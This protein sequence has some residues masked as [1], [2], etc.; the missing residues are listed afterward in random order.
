MLSALDMYF[1]VKDYRKQDL[2]DI[3][4]NLQEDLC[5]ERPDILHVTSMKKRMHRKERKNIYVEETYVQHSH[6]VQ[7][8]GQ[9]EK[10]SE[11]LTKISTGQ[12]LSGGQEEIVYD[13]LE[14]FKSGQKKEM[15][16]TDQCNPKLVSG[17]KKKC[18]LNQKL[19]IL[20][21]RISNVP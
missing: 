10:E 12:R 13:A 1:Y 17:Q 2:M 3:M 15:T 5:V 21:L 20:L 6:S 18:Y 4:Y 19:Q 16:I 9:S 7:S 11:V 14:I 8:R